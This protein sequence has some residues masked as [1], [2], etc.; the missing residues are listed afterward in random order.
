M[1]GEKSASY[2]VDLFKVSLNI[3]GCLRT[4]LFFNE[5]ERKGASDAPVIFAVLHSRDGGGSHADGSVGNTSCDSRL[6]S[7][8]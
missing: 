2:A 4:P 3:V 8:A 7:G 1:S 5:K 6:F